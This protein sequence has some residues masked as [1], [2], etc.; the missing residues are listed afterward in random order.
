MCLQRVP[1]IVFCTNQ[2]PITFNPTWLV[3]PEM[4]RGRMST[5]EIVTE[6]HKQQIHKQ[7]HKHK[8]LFLD[9]DVEIADEVQQMLEAMLVQVF[10]A[11][12]GRV[13]VGRD[14]VYRNASFR[15]QLSDVKEAQSDVLRPGT[16]EAVS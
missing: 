9:V 1:V 14:V 4:V 11:D 10:R 13:V 15:H 16:E 7:T 3:Q 5:T 8:T 6:S 12:V 2:I